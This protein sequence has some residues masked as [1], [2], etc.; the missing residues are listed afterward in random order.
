MSSEKSL[1]I[2]LRLVEFSETSVIATLF[3]EDFGKVSALAKG[4]RRP[5]GPFEA[6][7]DLL[8][9][10]R[11]VF[12]HKSSDALDLLTEAKLERRFRAAARSLSHL[13]AG[14]YVA[15]LLKDL[16]DD[17]DPHPQLFHAANQTLFELDGGC[18]LATTILRFELV[19]LQELGHL[20]SLS[21]CVGCGTEVPVGGRIAFGQLAGGVLCRECRVGQRQV[22]S[23]SA[24]VIDVL[25]RFADPTDAWRRTEVDRGLRGELRGVLNR[26]LANLLGRKPR[27]HRYL[28]V[29]A[30]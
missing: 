3:T 1:A 6:A 16:T 9:V 19:A 20:P 2:V 30:E 17:G 26:Y 4:A 21:R 10:C 25:R 14:Y 24:G 29:L 28:G 12:L 11:I 7:L 8:A 5:K 15:E 18:D 22:V 13:Y 27:M 23:V